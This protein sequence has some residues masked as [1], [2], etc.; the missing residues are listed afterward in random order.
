M[1]LIVSRSMKNSHATTAAL[2]LAVGLTVSAPA[3]ANLLT[4]GSFEDA[5]N[6]VDQGNDTM[7]LDVGSTTMSGWMVAGSE[8][9]AWIGPTNPYSGAASYAPDGNYF[10]DL[11]GYTTSIGPFSGVTQTIG[12]SVGSTYQLS[13]ELGDDQ[14]YNGEYLFD[15]IT[16]SAGATSQTF[17]SSS[18]VVYTDGTPD[19]WTT[20][21]LDF[22]ATA[23]TTTI[24]LIG[25]QGWAYI[26]L[27]NVSVT[28]TGSPSPAPEPA[29]LA[30]LSAGV[31]GL[32][33]IRRKR[34]Q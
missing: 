3:S 2:V 6:F 23:D 13:F 21:T 24:S 5:T 32:G 8:P 27:D 17:D 4:N 29:S 1:P 20:E 14:V 25:G 9:L 34:I 19:D 28:L 30:L 26:G 22:T 15:A 11:T 16:A 33:L 7:T 12:T 18:A 10:L 31:A